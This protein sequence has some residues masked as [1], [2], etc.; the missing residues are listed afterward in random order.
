MIIAGPLIDRATGLPVRARHVKYIK[1]PKNPND[2]YPGTGH[3][4]AV[5]TTFKMTVPPGAGA[6]LRQRVR[7]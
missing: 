1:L 6:P 4:G 5:V 7:G 3:G 2:G